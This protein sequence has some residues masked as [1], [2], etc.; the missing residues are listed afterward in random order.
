MEAKRSFKGVWIPREIWLNEELS[1][2]EKCLLTEIDSL[3]N[4]DGCTAGNDY[5]A[6]FFGVTPRQISKYV[7]R[8]EEKGLIS[9]E[10]I[11]RNRRK[12]LMEQKFRQ[13]GTK[14]P[15]ADGTKVPHNNT[16][17]NN[18]AN[19]PPRDA[20]RNREIEEIIK[21]FEAV[22]PNTPRLYG[23]PN[24]RASV[25]RMLDTHGYEK[26]HKW[27]SSLPQIVRLRGAPQITTP[28]QFEEKLGQLAIFTQQQSN[29]KYNI[30]TV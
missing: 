13:P 5:F 7:S 29:A 25:S 2:T 16:G 26:L 19:T 14:V 15:S 30:A 28:M 20:A 4:A 18:T 23:R 27:V 1:V 6:R 11:G 22:N 12:I 9:V 21:L 10:M 8:L 24:Q 17:N 3:D